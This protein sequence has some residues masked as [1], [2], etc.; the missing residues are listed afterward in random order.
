MGVSMNSLNSWLALSLAQSPALGLHF[1]F[2]SPKGISSCVFQVAFEFLAF[3]SFCL[4][5]VAFWRWAQYHLWYMS[6]PPKLKFPLIWNAGWAR[7][8]AKIKVG[9]WRCCEDCQQFTQSISSSLALGQTALSSGSLSVKAAAWWYSS[10][11]FMSRSF[12]P[13][14]P[15]S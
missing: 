6:V 8:K 15:G 7:K 14:K 1:A 4:T 11:W 9:Q 12:H 2:T 3:L 5:N 13:S 10:Q